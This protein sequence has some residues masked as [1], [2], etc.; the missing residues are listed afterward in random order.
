MTCKFLILT[1]QMDGSYAS[2]FEF[3]L[4]A[5]PPGMRA[6]PVR[7]ISSNQTHATCNTLQRCTTTRIGLLRG[8]QALN[9]LDEYLSILLI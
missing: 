4:L 9:I 3:D 8:R 7:L 1:A 2:Y 6:Y 5:M